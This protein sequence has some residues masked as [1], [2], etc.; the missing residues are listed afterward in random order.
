[1]MEIQEAVRLLEKKFRDVKGNFTLNDAAAVTGMAVDHA[2]EALDAMM[3][4]YV[5]RLQVTEN[6]DLI[7]SFG[8]SLQRRGSK[9]WRERLDDVAEWAWKIFKVI[10]KVWITITLVVYFVIFLVLLV[11][12][13]VA[14]SSGKGSRKSSINL[15]SVFNIFASIFRWQTVTSTIAYRT[16]RDGLKYRSYESRRSPIN[17]NKKSFI[18]SV[19]DFVFGP[20]RVETDPLANEKE[21]AAYLRQN[22]GI[23]TPAE[24]VALAGWKFS[25]A[26][27]FFSSCLVRFKGDPVISDQG[28]VYG[29]FDQ[30]GRT[31]GDVSD[32]KI[33][34]YWDEYEPEYE[35]TGNTGG[36]NFGIIFMNLFNLAFASLFTWAGVD[37]T[38]L[39]QDNEARWVIVGL[40]W[41]PFSFSVI[42]FLV[43]LIRSFR[44]RRLR[45]ERRRANIRKR[46]MRVVF[47]RP[48]Y[49]VQVEEV[50][51]GVNSDKTEKP[52]TEKEVTNELH[53]MLG[54]FGGEMTVAE[55]G[56]SVYSFARILAEMSE[57]HAVRKERKEDKEL[58]RTL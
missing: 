11:A 26:E 6:G 21:V 32:S 52:L 43:P 7:Y 18:S 48:D 44:V 41:V 19:Y 2:R 16:D 8:P 49:Q 5:C 55:D 58:G 25:E 33:E 46:I 17:E 53:R 13:I 27:R 22:K 36:R 51:Q 35:I 34:Y 47:K 3:E 56:T 50:V 42:F 39:L 54:D 1:M 24:L 9:T 29:R 57:A 4:R 28:V 23:L 37:Q 15:G 38:G 45:Q 30:I 14:S 12:L 40:G 20:P 10:F 31:T